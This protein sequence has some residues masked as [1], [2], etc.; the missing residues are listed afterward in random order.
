MS[1]NHIFPYFFSCLIFLDRRKQRKREIIQREKEEE[2]LRV[3]LIETRLNSFK[4]HSNEKK[5]NTCEDIT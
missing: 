1:H 5:K 3:G 4:V 2:N